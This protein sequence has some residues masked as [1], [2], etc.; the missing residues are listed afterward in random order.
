MEEYLRSNPDFIVF[1]P[2]G[3][4][5]DTDNEH[6]LVI[7]SPKSG[8]LAFWTQS[9]CENFGNN[10][11]E[12]SRSADGETWSK[13]VTVVGA[14]TPEDK[15]A[16]WQFP[17][18]SKNGRI[19]LF[20]LMEGDKVDLDRPTS[21][22]M[23]CIYSD[24]N[25]H[26][27]SDPEKIS[28]PRN[29]FDHPDP[30]VP[31]NWIVWQVP[32]RIRSGKVLVGYTHWTS[33]Q[34]HNKPP[35]GWYSRDSRCRFL[36]FENIDDNPAPHDLQIEWFEQEEGLAVPFP[37][38]DDIS[39]AQEPS[40]SVLPDGRIFCVMRT[41]TGYIYYSLLDADGA[42]WT[43]PE[44]LCDVEGGKPIKQPIAS[45][46]V[47]ALQDGRYILI[48]HN[49]DGHLGEFG[50]GDALHNRRPAFIRI[51]E[52][53]LESKQPIWF[54]EAKQ[55]LDSDGV[56]IGPK[57]T[58]EIA[59]YPSLTEYQGQRILWYPDRKFFLLG[60]RLPDELLAELN[61]P[62]GNGKIS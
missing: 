48:Y 39:V 21:G 46:P 58:C 22:W 4:S 41:F 55:I 26:S 11:V 50:P 44:V 14:K 60:K 42:K 9:S 45:C 2:T 13:P 29:R 30:T 1:R 23:G 10:H 20:Y 12:M 35:A 32:I 61:I 49:N 47:Y 8:L 33:P 34:Y 59:T 36:R 62:T 15:Q 40:I 24:D 57:Q 16:S 6:F 52:F 37:G 54:S 3:D 56:C 53:R 38:R 27:W 7:E 51:G 28:M 25:G 5:P 31:K 18:V 19:Y 17:V 43:K